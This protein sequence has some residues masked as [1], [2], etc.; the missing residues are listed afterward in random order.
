MLTAPARS[1]SLILGL[2]W[3]SY[4]PTTGPMIDIKVVTAFLVEA[5]SVGAL[6]CGEGRV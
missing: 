1:I 4:A 3:G 5:G 2:D 6:L